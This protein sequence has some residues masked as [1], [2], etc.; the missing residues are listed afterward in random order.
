VQVDD[1]TYAAGLVEHAG[2]PEA[3]AKIYATFGAGARL[4]YSA[5]VSTTVKDLTGTDPISLREALG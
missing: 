3:V 1:D 5:V 4:G 2:L